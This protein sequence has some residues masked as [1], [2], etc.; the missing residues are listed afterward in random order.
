MTPSTDTGAHYNVQGRKLFA[1]IARLERRAPTVLLLAGGGGTT[2]VW[3]E[4]QDAVAAIAPV[5]SYDRAGLG[6]SDPAEEKQS[7]DEIVVDALTLIAEA[8]LA[9]PFILVGHSVGGLHARHL[10]AQIPSDVAGLVLADSSHDEQ[11][12]RLAEAC[13]AVLESEY[14]ALLGDRETLTG[15]GWL[16]D[17]ARSSWRLDVPLI[18]IEH[19]RAGRPNP[20]PGLSEADFAA[21]ERAW[22]AMQSDLATWSRHGELREADRSGH[23]IPGDQPEL[24]TA[25][26]A[27][28]LATCRH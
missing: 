5:C 22:H 26:I 9:P 3:A 10:A 2:A 17:G 18:A 13:P 19:R 21:F 12:W 15:A 11:V 6:E 25:A 24:V 27:D 8:N 28:I 1:R 16:L 4:V 14:G 23:G 20:F 7:L